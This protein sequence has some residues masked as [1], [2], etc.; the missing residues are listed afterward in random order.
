MKL[1]TD[2]ERFAIR[3]GGWFSPYYYY[4]DSR[5]TWW[6]CP[7]IVFDNCWYT[8]LN[9]RQILAE[10]KAKRKRKEWVVE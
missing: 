9:A 4:D 2:G 5:K 6:S 1:V 3:C 7:D 10:L 8:E